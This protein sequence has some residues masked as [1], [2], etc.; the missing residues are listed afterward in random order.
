MLEEDYSMKLAFVQWRKRTVR[1]SFSTTPS[2]R[3][4]YLR[5]L[6]H[7]FYL[8]IFHHCSV[9]YER[10]DDPK[11]LAAHPAQT[12]V[13]GGSRNSSSST[14]TGDTGDGVK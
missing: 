4:I 12:R 3:I 8:F 6:F 14:Q 5:C 11:E 7:G 10:L 1:R 9:G 2:N 13:G